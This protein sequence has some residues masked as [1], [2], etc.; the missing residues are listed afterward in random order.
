MEY[1]VWCV[2]VS[3]DLKSIEQNLVLFQTFAVVKAEL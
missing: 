3:W 2:T 1:F